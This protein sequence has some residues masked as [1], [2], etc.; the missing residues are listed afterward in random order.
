MKFLNSP[1][2]IL[3]K[4]VNELD[5]QKRKVIYEE[6]WRRERDNQPIPNEYKKSLF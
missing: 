4:R 6:F 2:A 5:Y 1:F 3:H